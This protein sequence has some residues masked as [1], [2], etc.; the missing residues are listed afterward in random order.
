VVY[1]GHYRGIDLKQGA[2]VLVRNDKHRPALELG[3]VQKRRDE[4][5]SRNERAIGGTREISAKGALVFARN[6][7]RHFV[8]A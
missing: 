2:N 3:G 6:L 5:T 7:K 8:A 1:S 4:L